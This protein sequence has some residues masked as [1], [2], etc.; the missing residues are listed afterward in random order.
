MEYVCD[1][2]FRLSESSG[3]GFMFCQQSGW[4]G[5]HPYCEEDPYAEAKPDKDG[6]KEADADGCG[7]DH[8]CDQLCQVL[9]G[10]RR[11]CYCE[12]GFRSVN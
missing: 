10:G 1:P 2:G 11:Q 8:G 6:G 12:E 5:V 3:K 4:M 7:E 9:D